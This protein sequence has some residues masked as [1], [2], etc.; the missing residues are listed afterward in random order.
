MSLISTDSII[1]EL[2]YMESQIPDASEF[3]EVV[4]NYLE[5]ADL[6]QDQYDKITKRFKLDILDVE[7]YVKQNNWKCVS[8]PR[9]FNSGGIPTDN[10]LLSNTIFGFTSEERAGIFAY[11]DLHGWF[12]DPSCYKTWIRLDSNIRNIVHGVKYYRLDGKGNLIEDENGETGIEFLHKNISKIKFKESESLKKK[13]SIQF[14]EKN[15]DKMFIRK[16]IV[17]P[18]F[19]RDKN[20]GNGKSIGLGGI[21]KL[22][23]KLIV[24]SNA[25]TTTQEFGFDSSDAMTANVQELILNIY[26]WFC[27][28]NNKALEDPGQGLSGKLGILRM[29]NT[30]KTSN[31]SSRLVISAA[32]LKVDRPE[33]LEVDFD[34]TSLPL[35]SAITEFRDFVM[36]NVRIFFENE[37]NGIETYP[38]VTAKGVQ[39]TVIPEAPEVIFSD[40]RIHKE[41]ERFL[42]GYNNR[43]V[44]VEVPVEGSKEKYYMK[45]KGR[46]VS[47]DDANKESDNPLYNRRLT[48]CDIFYLAT[49]EATKDKHVL[50]T[51]FPIKNRWH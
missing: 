25:L 3:L 13:M 21:N 38:V 1:R 22:Y 20:S 11:I 42:H 7:E 27:G 10:G 12:M 26:D 33:D 17:I 14:L 18:P 45:F 2:S 19:Y 37:F 24:A 46:G 32:E 51:R 35:Y 31:F 15:R 50:I 6:S 5:D 43:F 30:S 41:M 4:D 47:L 16:Y 44:P 49:V 39:K 28:N 34:K 48:W 36:Y 8:D 29:T 9:A 23:N 40:E